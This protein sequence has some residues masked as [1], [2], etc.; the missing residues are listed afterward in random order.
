MAYNANIP[1]PGDRLK[2]SQPELLANFQAINTLVGI[3]HATFGDPNAGKHTVIDLVPQTGSPPVVFPAGENVIYSFLDPITSQN[4]I[5]INKTQQAAVVQVPAT[6][7]VLSVTNF[8]GNNSSGWSYLPSG[9]ILKWGLASTAA[10]GE[11]TITFPV[12]A[13]I[14]VFVQCFNVQI[15]MVRGVP[16]DPN[17][18]ATVHAATGLNFTVYSGQRTVASSPVQTFFYWLAIG[19]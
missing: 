7:S 11:Q 1:Q 9:V 8:P 19:R 15:T 12:G 5:Y 10:G 17:L 18:F 2:D 14:P 3:N 6:A 13:T 4:E 16:G